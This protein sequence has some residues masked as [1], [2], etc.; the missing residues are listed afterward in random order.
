[1]SWRAEPNSSSQAELARF[2]PRKKEQPL[3]QSKELRALFADL[4]TFE[5]VPITFAPAE[6]RQKWQPNI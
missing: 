6:L 4:E 3:K 2:S 5:E 1:L